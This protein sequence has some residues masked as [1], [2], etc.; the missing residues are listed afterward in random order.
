MKTFNI[1][2]RSVKIG[3]IEISAVILGEKGRGRTQAIVPCPENASVLEPGLS[4]TNRPRLNPSSSNAGWL[5]RIS[6]EGS[7]VRGANGNVSAPP[8]M[9]SM[10]QVVA[11]GNGAFGDAGRI[12]TWVDLILATHLESFYLRVKPSRGDA[13]ILLFQE[14]AT[15]AK[16]SY[17]EAEALDLDLYSST[18]TSKGEMITF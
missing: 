11:K 18:P 12:G 15:P 2:P 9:A 6:T 10:I 14:G 13:Y 16:I 3:E 5:A 1:Q 8:S 4:K 17:S 7:Y